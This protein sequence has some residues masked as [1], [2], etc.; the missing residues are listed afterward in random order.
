ML[1]MFKFRRYEDILNGGGCSVCDEI[2]GSFGS[3]LCSAEA[4]DAAV[5]ATDTFPQEV[6]ETNEV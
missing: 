4:F 2:G 3:N 5:P 1:E 6:R